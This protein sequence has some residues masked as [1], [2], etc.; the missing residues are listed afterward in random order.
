LVVYLG[1]RSDLSMEYEGILKACRSLA[2]EVESVSGKTAWRR[3]VY[4][5]PWDC[6]L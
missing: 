6:N 4:L 1:G 3:T 2:E 5:R